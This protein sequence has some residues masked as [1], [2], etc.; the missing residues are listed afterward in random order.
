MLQVLVDFLRHSCENVQNRF[1][2]EQLEI[3]DQC[4]EISLAETFLPA[5][6]IDGCL[7]LALNESDDAI[8]LSWSIWLFE[9]SHYS[10]HGLYIY[11]KSFLFVREGFLVLNRVI[12][13]D[14]HVVLHEG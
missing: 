14:F 13:L 7:V 2:L 8:K 9:P 5:S 3:V 6:Y 4:S 10:S 11:V 12:V 1:L